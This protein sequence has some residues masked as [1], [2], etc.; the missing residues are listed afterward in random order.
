VTGYIDFETLR[1][2]G[3]KHNSLIQYCVWWTSW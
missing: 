3:T 1:L 2:V